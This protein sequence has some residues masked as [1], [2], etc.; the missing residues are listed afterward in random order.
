MTDNDE[1]ISLKN[2]MWDSFLYTRIQQYLWS[3]SDL[4]G[5]MV[6]TGDTDMAPTLMEGKSSHKQTHERKRSVKLGS[7]EDTVVVVAV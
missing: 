6:G 4:A 7:T 1:I 2:P 3:T 5:P